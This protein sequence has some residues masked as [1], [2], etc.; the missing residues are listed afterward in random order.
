M[1]NNVKKEFELY[2]PMRC[3]L[4][5]YLE[6]KYPGATII[7]V[8]SHAQTLDLFLEK[9]GVIDN[10][11]QTVGLD[12]QIDVL[13]IIIKGK[14]T[15]IVFIEAKKTQLNLHDLGQLWA[16][17]KLCDP[18]EA[19]LLSSAGLGSLNKI[20]NNF[21][22]LDLLDFGDGKRIKQMQVGKWDTSANGIDFRTLIP[23]N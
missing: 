13:G 6:E 8:D 11:P 19:F 9:Y 20:L 17:C 21:N 15:S 10:Y 1:A 7:T 23:K 5:T 18:A 16:Y 14:K 2:E 3:W 4:Q 12:I 22:R